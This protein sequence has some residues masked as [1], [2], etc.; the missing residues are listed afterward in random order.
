M[1]SFSWPPQNPSPNLKVAL[2]YLSALEQYDEGKLMDT[3]DDTLKHEI[4]PKSLRRPV[5]NK[6]HFRQ[7]FRS[8]A[9]MFEHEREKNSVS[10]AFLSFYSLAYKYM[11]S[12]QFTMSLRSGTLLFCM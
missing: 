9:S 11:Y 7:Y 12:G 2:A 1:S 8:L 4:F 3:F 6:T 5:L 10:G